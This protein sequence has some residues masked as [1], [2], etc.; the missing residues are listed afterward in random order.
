METV[1]VE[2]MDDLYKK[3]QELG[4]SVAPAVV[5]PMLMKG[6][7]E[8]QSAVR[9]KAPKGK[10]GNLRKGIKVKQLDRRGDNP[11]SVIVK[12]TAPHDHLIEFGTSERYQKTTG[13]YTGAGT[14][15]PFFRPAVLANRDRIYTEIVDGL[16]KSVESVAK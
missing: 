10:T 12:S 4:K 11:R 7:K 1:R 9:D 13:R 15:N 8:L 2:G 5:E 16:R 3:L 14:A 6:G